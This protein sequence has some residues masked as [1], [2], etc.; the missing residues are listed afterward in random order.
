MTHRILLTAGFALAM[1]TPLPAA[2]DARP[3]IG[4]FLSMTPGVVNLG[5]NERFAIQPVL[6]DLAEIGVTDIYFNHNHGR[7]GPFYHPTKVPHLAAAGI[8]GKRD[9]LEELLVEADA[10]RLRVWLLW[11]PPSGSESRKTEAGFQDGLYA[12]DDITLAS[13]DLRET[14][15]RLIDEVADR[16]KPRHP[17]LT[18]IYLHEIHA[19]LDPMNRPVDLARFKDFCRKNFGAEF[20]G[21]AMPEPAANDVWAHR[22]LLYRNHVT[23]EFTRILADK[24][25]ARGLQTAF[26]HYPAETSAGWAIGADALDLEPFVDRMWECSFAL[27]NCKFYYSIKGVMLDVGPSYRH[28]NLALYYASAFHG[29]P[30]SFFEF[31]AP[32]YVE[33]IRARFPPGSPWHTQYGDFYTGHGGKTEREVALF[34]GKRNLGAWLGAMGRWQGGTPPAQVAAA[35]NPTP[36]LMR[37]PRGHGALFVETVSALMQ[38]LTRR[39]DVDGIVGGSLAMDD[40]LARYDLVLIPEHQGRDLPPAVFDR[41][42]RHVEAGGR[43]LLVNT[44]VTTSAR[45]LTGEEDRTA[46]FCGCTLAAAGATPVT[47]AAAPGARLALPPPER[48]WRRSALSNVTAEVLATDSAGAPLLTRRRLGKGEVFCSALAFQPGLEE[49]FVSI[50]ELCVRP[51]LRL[52]GPGATRF[53]EA[54]RKDGQVCVSLWDLGARTLRADAQPLGLAGDTFRARDLVTGEWLSGP[55]TAEA[56]ARDGVPVPILYTNQP[57]IVVLGAPDALEAYAGIYSNTAVFRDLARRAPLV[58]NPQVPILVPEGA[59]LAVGVYQRGLGAEELITCFARAGLRAFPMPRL[60][61]EA[62]NYPRVLVIPQVAGG[63]EFFNQAAP[64]VRRFVERGGGVLLTHDAVGFRAHQPIFPELGAG[65][66]NV[67]DARLAVAGPHPVT[68]GF[69]PGAPFEP[70]FRFDHVTIKPGKQ[71]AILA[72]NAQ[73]APVLAAGACGK[74]RVVLMGTLPGVS[75]GADQAGGRPAPIAEP[76][77]RLLLQ[78][79]RWLA[80]TDPGP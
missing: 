56:L 6:R 80:G 28:N 10:L 30:L 2:D 22:Y 5:P 27:E 59:G 52:A 33:K 69:A 31:G 35:I 66:E 36:F 64:A 62:L 20:P 55:L 19:G 11:T 74:G 29:Y 26:C 18:G 50:V 73:G 58:E 40:N 37:H 68:A 45:D 14:Y 79:V 7:G 25:R 1:M 60:D 12:L 49:L 71:A 65:V 53:L 47:L 78:A 61:T 16:Y 51:R 39:L 17:S 15:G 76:E 54:V 38:A 48:P 34:F 77:A 67:K 70:G 9:F 8:L 75:A 42:R 46:A 13:P 32:L 44:P 43:L 72:R 57:R 4:T 21:A 24:A 23:T 41:Y 63:V 3:W